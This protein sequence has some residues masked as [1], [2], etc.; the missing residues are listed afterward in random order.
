MAGTGKETSA[1]SIRPSE[2]VTMRNRL[3]PLNR[4]PGRPERALYL[5]VI[6]VLLGSLLFVMNENRQMRHELHAQAERA[7]RKAQQR[8][9][10]ATQQQIHEAALREESREARC[11]IA[12]IARESE[13]YD[14]VGT[15]LQE[16]Q[17]RMEILTLAQEAVVLAQKQAQNYYQVAARA[18]VAKREARAKGLPWDSSELVRANRR[19]RAA[20]PAYHPGDL[21]ARDLPDLPADDDGR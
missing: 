5:A 9:A 15:A 17:T 16:V 3:S 10:L 14:Q 20:T 19:L 8:A 4:M 7:Q 21:R 6:G 18:E 13:K 2:G 12:D 11:L 1:V